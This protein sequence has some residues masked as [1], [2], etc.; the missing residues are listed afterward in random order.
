MEKFRKLIFVNLLIGWMHLVVFSLCILLTFGSIIY[1]IHEIIDQN[2]QIQNLVLVFV[3]GFFSLTVFGSLTYASHEFV[4]GLK[5]RDHTR[6]LMFRISI[7]MLF[8]LSCG[9]VGYMIINVYGRS[10][11]LDED[12]MVF[13]MAAVFSLSIFEFLVWILVYIIYQK[14]R[15]EAKQKRLEKQHRRKLNTVAEQLTILQPAYSDLHTKEVNKD[16]KIVADENFAE[17]VP[18]EKIDKKMKTPEQH[19]SLKNFIENEK[20]V[21]EKAFQKVK[22]E[23]KKILEPE[24]VK[25]ENLPSPPEGF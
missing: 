4:R 21:T 22:S 15:M 19:R 7:S 6:M 2:K 20:E 11:S 1:Y 25:P 23:Q 9:Y 13:R 24:E 10:I 18:F 3:A 16:N 12:G 8:I 17:E 5:T 14:L